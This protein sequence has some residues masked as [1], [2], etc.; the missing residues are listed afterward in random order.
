MSLQLAAK[1]L[2]AHGRGPDSHLVHMSSDEINSLQKLAQSHGGSL[3]VNPHTG[4]PEAGFLSAIL[5]MAL[6]AVGGAFLPEILAG[7]ALEGSAGL[8]SAG[9]VGAA[10]YAMTGS[11]GQGIMAGFGAYSGANLEQS[12]A[13]FGSAGDQAAANITA[14]TTPPPTPTTNTIAPDTS[15]TLTPDAQPQVAP[16]YNLNAQGF[17]Q[18]TP[19]GTQ[20]LPS[21]GGSVAG[22]QS[23]STGLSNV[24]A[25]PMDYLKAPGNLF[26]VGSVA[27]PL[28]LAAARA[29][30]PSPYTLQPQQ[31]NNPLKLNSPDFQGFNPQGGAPYYQAQYTNYQ[32]NPYMAKRG[33][34]MDVHHMATGGKSTTPTPTPTIFD[35]GN[36]FNF[37]TPSYITGQTETPGFFNQIIGAASGPGMHGHVTTPTPTPAP[38]PNPVVTPTNPVYTPQY[39]NY[40]TG[41]QLDSWGNP[42]FS[43]G[44]NVKKFADAG[45]VYDNVV[46][47]EKAL[48]G[49]DPYYKAMQDPLDTAHN[50]ALANAKSGA[51]LYNLNATDYANTSPLAQMSKNQIKVVKGLQPGTLGSFNAGPAMVAQQDIASEK[52][53]NEPYVA[54]RGGIMH[55]GMSHHGSD[56][57]SYSDGGHL[58]RGPGDGVSDSIPATIGGHQPARLAEGEFVI[59]ARIVS[60]LGNGSTDAG[61]KRLYEMMDRIKAKRAKTKDIA[62]DTKAY[63]FLP[64]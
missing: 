24:M 32:T 16:N 14:S 51:G 3:T 36:Q 55:G 37:A 59:P 45:K 48:Q 46:M 52:Q 18:N 2:E 58:L 49:L 57:G 26:K 10:D 20:A 19:T 8:V 64:A 6:G 22:P 4:L 34:L 56:L 39:A 47:T 43:R 33:G 29:S 15:T 9:L 21:G 13:N 41:Q 35:R 12:I 61:A 53:S 27:A 11:L 23:F 30:Q 44:G 31:I 1:H 60:E 54:A 7:T 63:K 25:R 28:A 50:M 38:T 5:P 62:A 17:P 42:L 40:Q